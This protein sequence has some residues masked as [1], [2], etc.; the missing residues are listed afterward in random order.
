M[1]QTK[2]FKRT[3]LPLS[4]KSMVSTL[5]LLI[6][7]LMPQGV[8][9]GACAYTPGCASLEDMQVHLNGTNGN[10]NGSANNEVV[11]SL[12][13]NY[14][15]D[16]FNYDGDNGYWD[17]DL[18]MK[19]DGQTLTFYSDY[20]CTTKVSTDYSTVL[21]GVWGVFG[22]SNEDHTIGKNKSGSGKKAYFKTSSGLKGYINIYNYYAAS[23]KWTTMK[24][25]VFIY[26]L[27]GHKVS[28]CGTYKRSGKSDIAYDYV[29]YLGGCPR[30]KNVTT[31]QSTTQKEVTISW[32]KE[33]YSI[34]ASDAT[35]ETRV[36]AY[37]VIDNGNWGVYRNNYTTSIQTVGNTATSAADNSASCS[38]SPHSYYVCYEPKATYKDNGTSLTGSETSKRG[39]S[40]S[41]SITLTHVWS[42]S[43]SEKDPA[44]CTTAA[45]HYQTCIYCGST[46]D[47][48]HTYTSSA[49]G[50]SLTATPA[51]AATCTEAGNNAYWTCSTCKKVFSNSTATKETTVA[52]QTIAA[53]D[54]NYTLQVAADA[55]RKSYSTCTSDEEYYYLCSV[56]R[57][58]GNTSWAK[59]GTMRSHSM[60]KYEGEDATCTANGKETYYV[61]SWS[62]CNGKYYKDN[63]AHTTNTF[64]NREETI[65]PAKGHGTGTKGY[66][67]TYTWGGS[68]D[69]A[70]CTFRLQCGSCGAEVFNDNITT[71]KVPA[72]HVD[73]TCARAGNERWTATGS[74]SKAGDATYN[75]EA[76]T[77]D[78]VIPATGLHTFDDVTDPH[79]TLCTV[80]DHSFF[81]YTSSTKNAVDPYNADAL[82]D[83]NDILLEFT[84]TYIDGKGVIEFNKPL[85]TI[86]YNT[87]YQKRA[88]TGELIL[89]ITVKTIGKNAFNLCSGFTKLILPNSITSIGESAFSGCAGLTGDLILPNT[90]T[91]IEESAFSECAGLKGNLILPNS[92]TSIGYG[93]FENCSNLRGDL[94]LPNTVESIEAWAFHNCSSFSG[95]IMKSVPAMRPNVFSNV[96]SNKT[97]VLSD[98]SYVYKGSNSYFPTVASVTAPCNLDLT[99]SAV[100]NHAN[101]NLNHGT[102]IEEKDAAHLVSSNC[103]TD[104]YHYSC[105]KCHGNLA[106]TYTA[107]G[108]GSH[109][110]TN[111]FLTASPVED[112]LYAYACDYGCGTHTDDHI[113]KDFYGEGHHLELTKDGEGNYSTSEDIIIND[114]A[115][116]YSSVD[117]SSPVDFT[118]ARV[119]FNRYFINDG[120][121]WSFIVPFDIPAAQAAQ[122]GTFYQY[123]THEGGKVYFDNI[124]RVGDGIVRANTAYF[125]E[126]TTDFTSIT[127][128][129]AEIKATTS[130]PNAEN[131]S[132]PG[133]YG[134][135]SQIDIPVGAYG[136]AM[137]DGQSTFAKAG[138]GNILRSFRAYL[139]L[140]SGAYMVKA[141]AIRG[142]QKGDVNG[143]GKISL[144]D[145]TLLVEILNGDAT[146]TTGA[147]DIDGKNG[148]TID[149]L[150]ILRNHILG[151]LNIED[152]YPEYDD[153]TPTGFS[154]NYD[155]EEQVPTITNSIWDR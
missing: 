125:F 9:A 8:W 134:T 95:V 68:Y 130:M 96:T 64:A 82:L 144:A 48:N 60:S 115:S 25:E 142:Q 57:T 120:G 99:G 38:S 150:K 28:V 50:H 37:N 100:A 87:F 88:F 33:T 113:I 20:A 59:A 131:P 65:I 84:N 34:P 58:K 101:L 56:C 12:K 118:A 93:A 62:C 153:Q 53:L 109:N 55:Y 137:H 154:I 104:T 139:W 19:I 32:Q 27:Y 86:G 70:T 22:D 54:H 76:Q 41:S 52:A 152:L 43:G 79:H 122:L 94:I 83:E 73:A 7:M 29:F 77:E 91:R 98:N 126:P 45:V 129:D 116:F 105:S 155:D 145:L 5:L 151:L 92:V 119:T 35:G 15:L 63:A 21:Q 149:D 67:P 75:G 61:C 133:L 97:V 102:K 107:A 80:C 128:D 138:T 127:V 141:H 30:P 85:V 13:F 2:H 135:Y 106:D 148:V 16:I 51:K 90:L 40:G 140:G 17:R 31:S 10:F 114:P 46:N 11:A 71:T 89:P 143:D 24:V 39:I 47:A 112:G 14:W 110:F 121:M 44:T 4:A 23:N 81:R 111:H 3:A 136:Y 123:R 69:A 6:A 132:E 18:T 42:N 49:L 26:D 78:Y 66:T 108:T 103:I 146:D 74:Y 147:A 36:K 72:N 117:F 1:K 124:A